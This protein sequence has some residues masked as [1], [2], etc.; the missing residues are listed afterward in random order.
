[1]DEREELGRKDEFS[2]DADVGQEFESMEPLS[3]ISEAGWH[4]P[5]YDALGE[6][7]KQA[8][9]EEKAA[10]NF[11]DR[12]S[13]SSGFDAVAY[14]RDHRQ[15]APQEP[16][17]GVV[18]QIWRAIYPA[19]IYLVGS[20][21]V[22]ML[23]AII[24]AIFIIMQRGVQADSAEM[25]DVLWDMLTEHAMLLM[26]VGHIAVLAIYLPIWKKT[27]QRY[28]LWNGGKI[29]GGTALLLVFFSI[30]V[31]FA[32]SFLVGLVRMAGA[33][34]SYDAIETS[35][36][37][38]SV[39][40]QALAI[41]LSGPIVEELCFRGITQNRLSNLN[42]MLAVFIQAVLFGVA[43]MNWL[44]GMYAFIFGF[45]LGYLYTE[46]RTLIVPIIGHITFNMT[47]VVLAALS[48]GADTSAV[49]EE[50]LST[51][52]YITV[53]VI[54]AIASAASF[55][56][57]RALMARVPSRRALAGARRGAGGEIEPWE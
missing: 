4:V 55:A 39:L 29:D 14:A 8:Q 27:K 11:A 26:F 33:F 32:L 23:V 53:A 12:Y 16:P 21:V 36:T 28:T 34:E 35:L 44:Q 22:T 40:M 50:P 17:Y 15:E 3:H 42:R 52:A 30:C 2:S 19:L 6:V 41:G 24:V 13:K 10:P 20:L 18:R 54:I 49:A 51:A 47:N 43:H 45:I 38:G 37:N 25:F 9:P 48:S 7:E 1:M 56:L 46:F 5:A 31:Y 57:F